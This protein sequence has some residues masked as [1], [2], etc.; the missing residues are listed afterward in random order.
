[1][2]VNTIKRAST[3][4]IDRSSRCCR[5]F[6]DYPNGGDGWLRLINFDIPNNQIKFETYSPVLDQFQTETVAQVGQFASQFDLNI[7]FSTRL[8]PIIIPP[9]PTPDLIIQEGNAGYLGTLDKELRS[10]G[11]DTFQRTECIDYG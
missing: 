6:R 4:P 1:M 10:D 2:T 3:T 8:V 7:D 11:A 9:P 5:I